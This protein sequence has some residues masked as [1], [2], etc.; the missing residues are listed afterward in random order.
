MNTEIERELINQDLEKNRNEILKEIQ[1]Q[2]AKLCE[3]QTQLEFVTKRIQKN[4]NHNWVT[5]FQMYEKDV[6]C[7]RCGLTDW[8][9]SRF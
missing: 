7:S 5:E 6:F 8:E 1:I 4:C 3:L 2:N 9:K